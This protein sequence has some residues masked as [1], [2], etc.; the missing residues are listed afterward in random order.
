LNGIKQISERVKETKVN[1]EKP[2][3]T[4]GR[5]P[6]RFLL[7]GFNKYLSDHVNPLQQRDTDPKCLTL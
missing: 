1:A 3:L 5:M 6:L 7:Q 4:Q 2:E